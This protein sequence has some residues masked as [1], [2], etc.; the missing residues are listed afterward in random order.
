[1]YRNRLKL[2]FGLAAMS[3]GLVGCGAMQPHSFEASKSQAYNYASAAKIKG[4]KDFSLTAAQ[5]HALVDNFFSVTDR[6]FRP[7]QQ[8]DSNILF[9]WVPEY[10]ADDRDGARTALSSAAFGAM[11]DG[12]YDLALTAVSGSR[13]ELENSGSLDYLYSCVFI[14]DAAIGCPAWAESGENLDNTCYMESLIERPRTGTK[15]VPYF[16]NEQERAFPILG[17]HEWKVS[18]LDVLLPANTPIDEY[19]LLL[20][21]SKNLPQWAF[22]FVPSRR[23][24][25]GNFTMPM[26]L[27][28]GTANYFIK[29]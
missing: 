3:I 20:S 25:D 9:A 8:T 2:V 10:L 4:V 5:Q 12:A 11:E 16:I 13:N 15:P 26:V 17:D 1:M 22:I 19:S 28:Q 14:E 23:D 6:K 27:S 24:K 21:I 7:H 18:T 29:P